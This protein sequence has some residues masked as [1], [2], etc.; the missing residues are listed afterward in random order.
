[1]NWYHANE[2]NASARFGFNS[3]AFSAFNLALG[4]TSSAGSRLYEDNNPYVSANPAKGL[5]KSGSSSIARSKCL[6]ALANPSLLRLFHSRRPFWYS[7][8]ASGL[9]VAF[10]ASCCAS[11]ASSSPFNS[12]ASFVAISFCRSRKSSIGFVN[13]LPQPRSSVFA[14][15]S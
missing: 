11:A 4:M 14:F 5:A 1:M 15:T 12:P 7:V 3:I 6:I 8:C 13:V 9:S 2:A 10:W